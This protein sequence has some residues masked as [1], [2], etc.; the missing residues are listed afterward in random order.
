MG[1]PDFSQVLCNQVDSRTIQLSAEYNNVSVP[2]RFTNVGL[3]KDEPKLHTSISAA[4]VNIKSI[5]NALG[6]N[7]YSAKVVKLA[8]DQKTIEITA[9]MKSYT[10]LQED[11]EG[12]LSVTCTRKG[13]YSF[14]NFNKIWFYFLLHTCISNI[15]KILYDFLDNCQSNNDCQPTQ[16]CTNGF[17]LGRWKKIYRLRNFD[18]LKFGNFSKMLIHISLNHFYEYRDL[19][20]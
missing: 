19:W 16:I 11:Q 7:Q 15:P 8:K 9:D 5:C 3:L 17:C 18:M 12:C 6:Y 4:E 13:C 20:S 10:K 14:L 2:L 1:L